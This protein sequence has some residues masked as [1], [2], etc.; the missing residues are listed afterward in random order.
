MFPFDDVIMPN[1][2]LVKQT[3]FYVIG[4]L[5]T[6]KWNKKRQD[7]VLE[8]IVQGY[9]VSTNKALFDTWK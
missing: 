7:Y 1:G 8:V 2:L 9:L 6:T 3:G 4:E 5:I